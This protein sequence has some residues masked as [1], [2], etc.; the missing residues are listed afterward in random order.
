MPFIQLN[1]VVV[2]VLGDACDDDD[3][4]DGVYDIVDNCRMVSNPDQED[5]NCKLSI[6]LNLTRSLRNSKIS[7]DV[8]HSPPFSRRELVNNNKSL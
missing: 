6:Q 7:I 2:D 3:D 8:R 4:D 1:I 5:S